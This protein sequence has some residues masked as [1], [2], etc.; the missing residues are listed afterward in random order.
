MMN[1]KEL[2]ISELLGLEKKK[3]EHIIPSFPEFDRLFMDLDELKKLEKS[4]L[5]K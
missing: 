1:K 3:Q 5:K 2:S 4:E